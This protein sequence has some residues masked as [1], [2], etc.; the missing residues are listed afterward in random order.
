MISSDNIDVARLILLHKDL[1]TY[2]PVMKLVC[3]DWYNILKHTYSKIDESVELLIKIGNLDTLK[4]IYQYMK[5]P[6]D[7][8]FCIDA[9]HYGRLEILQWLGLIS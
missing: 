6:F 1:T 5:L 9:A 7:Y 2:T 3:R 8:D 4:W